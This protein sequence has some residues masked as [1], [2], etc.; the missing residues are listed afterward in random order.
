MA[1]G[2]LGHL[3]RKIKAIQLRIQLKIENEPKFRKSQGVAF[4][5]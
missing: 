4:T 2:V 3:I 5:C 1:M